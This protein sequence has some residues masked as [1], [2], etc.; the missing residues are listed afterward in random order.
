MQSLVRDFGEEAAT[1]VLNS[2]H[3]H[4]YALKKVVEEEGLDCE[5]EMRR[6]YD[7]FCNDDEAE[8][9]RQYVRA[10]QQAGQQWTDDVD[11]VEEKFA[12]QVMRNVE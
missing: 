12:E 10:C 1:E 5:F 3:A 4:V 8:A 7:V 6:S 11:F 9:A 2:L